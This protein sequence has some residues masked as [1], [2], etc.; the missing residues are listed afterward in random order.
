MQK[1]VIFLDRDGTINVDHGYV[2]KKEQWEFVPQAIAG[3]KLLQD[4]GYALAII[5]NQSGIARKLYTTADTRSLHEYM[6]NTLAREGVTIDAIAFCPH[7]RDSTCDCRK[8]QPGMA[9]HIEEQIGAIDYARSWTIGD[10]IADLGFG[11]HTGTKTALIRSR[12]WHDSDLTHSPD[13]ITDS[14][15]KAAQYIKTEKI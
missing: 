6:N 3:L 12:Y 13:L 5:T 10:K 2:S 9:R 11:I 8:P 15:Y 14:L 4:A 7:D 1:K